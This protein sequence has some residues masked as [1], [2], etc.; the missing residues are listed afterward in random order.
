MENYKV[1]IQWV[2]LL[3]RTQQEVAQILVWRSITAS[4][5]AVFLTLCR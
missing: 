3:L 5:F 4:Y 1:A 2:T